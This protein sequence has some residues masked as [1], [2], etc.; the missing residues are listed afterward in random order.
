MISMQKK[1]TWE[2]LLKLTKIRIQWDSFIISLQE[3]KKER[4]REKKE[5]KPQ[6]VLHVLCLKE[7]K[8]RKEKKRKQKKR[9]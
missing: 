2:F 9:K 3:G 7:R 1:I 4:N 8:N 6:L 5:S